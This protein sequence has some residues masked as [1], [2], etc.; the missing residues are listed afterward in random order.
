MPDWARRLI[1]SASIALGSITLAACGSLALVP[2]APIRCDDCDDWNQPQEPFLIYGNTYYVGVAGLSSI[3]INTSE[4]LIL[5]DAGLPQ[6]AG[7][8]AANIRKLGFDPRDIQVIAVS[9]AHFDHVGGIAA[10]QRLS[11][12]LVFTSVPTLWVMRRGTL[13]GDD[14]QFDPGNPTMSFPAVP[15]ANAID[16]GTAPTIGDVQ[17]R[18]IYTPG[19]TP[20]GMTWT[21][22][23]CEGGHCLDVVY[24]DSLSPV[25]AP[26]FRFG[27]GESGAGGQIHR[28]A[29]IIAE[30]DCDIFL[31]P[32]PFYF[33]IKEKLQQGRAAFIDDQGCRRYAASMLAR[34][35]RRLTDE[36][37]NNRR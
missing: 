28:S 33:G 1:V 7:L 35:Q 8:I 4:G 32:H 36:R 13:A 18:G 12:A 27:S 26:A 5:L 19:H 24:A 37:T 34:L 22:Q 3:L 20:G 31:A 29:D 9:H 10:L 6:S 25:S 17:I 15:G 30:L 2:D 23:A 14:P 16:D 11:E 21:W